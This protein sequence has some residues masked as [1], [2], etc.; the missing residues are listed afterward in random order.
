MKYWQI[1][2]WWSQARSP[3]HQIS[4]LYGILCCVTIRAVK[5]CDAHGYRSVNIC[6]L[7]LF[8]LVTLQSVSYVSSSWVAPASRLWVGGELSLHQRVPFP[9]SGRLERFNVSV[10]NA[11]QIT[12]DE[13]EFSNILGRY[14]ERDGEPCVIIPS[15]CSTGLLEF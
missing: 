11:D 4:R 3:N 14:N 13:F 2:I 1:L 10:L 5:F 8:S 15:I 12:A 6:L 9:A 7:Q